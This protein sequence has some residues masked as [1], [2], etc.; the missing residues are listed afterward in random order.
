MPTS[1]PLNRPAYRVDTLPTVTE[2]GVSP[3]VSANAEAGI[4]DALPP[5]PLGPPVDGGD[6]VDVDCEF[7]DAAKHETGDAYTPDGVGNARATN[8]ALRMRD[9][10]QTRWQPRP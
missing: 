9:V 6:V 5:L 7:V 8:V 10:S 3:V 2:V 1:E 4:V